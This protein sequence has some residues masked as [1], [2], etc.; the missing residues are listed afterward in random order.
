M[1]PAVH[2]NSRSL[3][4]SSS[5][6]EP[7]D[8][9]LRV[10]FN[11]SKVCMY[12]LIKFNNNGIKSMRTGG[13]HNSVSVYITKQLMYNMKR[14]QRIPAF[15]IAKII[16]LSRRGTY[17]DVQ[18]IR[19][20]I[21]YYV[22]SNNAMQYGIIHSLSRILHTITTINW[23]TADTQQTHMWRNIIRPA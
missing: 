7:S 18:C 17:C 11:Y 23:Q 22:M 19:S 15:H 3:L 1:C 4:R 2:I 8:P 21:K 10:I 12:K 9:P 6:H 20:S 5:T 14:K 13:I 16:N